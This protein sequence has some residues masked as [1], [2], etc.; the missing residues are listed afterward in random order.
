[1]NFLIIFLILILIG[2][3]IVQVG[4]VSDLASKLRG[5]EEVQLQNSNRSAISLVIFGVLFLVLCVWSA[6]YYKDQMLGYG[7]LKSASEHGSLVD[8]MFNV[9]LFFT[10]IVF[11]LTHIA[12][13]WYSY[14][15]RERKNGK[16]AFMAHDTKLEMVWT[17]VPAIVMAF[18]VVKGLV[19]WNDIMTDLGPEDEYLEIEATGYQFAWDIRYTGPDN[20]LGRK[21][22]RLI[23]PANN[24]LGLEWAD[25]ASLD[26]I[27]LGGSDVIKLPVDT[28][29]RVKITSKD[30]L[31]NFYLP[32]FRVKMDAVPGLPTYFIF[33]PTKTTEEFRLELSEYPEWNEPYDP[34]DPE[35]KTRWEEFNYELACAE[36][37]GKG[38]YSMRRIVEIVSKEEYNDWIAGQQSFYMKNIRGTE[39][40]PYSDKLFESEILSRKKELTA[41]FETKVAPDFE[42]KEGEDIILLKHVFYNTGSAAL[43]DLS[44]YELDNVSELMKKYPDVRLELRGHTDSVGDDEMNMELSNSRASNVKGYLLQKGIDDSRL[45]WKGYGE[46][47]PVD[48]NDTEEG[49]QNNRRTELRIISK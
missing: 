3:V 19:A 30:V 31:H 21:D 16:A 45:S 33:T 1:M 14:K 41:E 44:K 5:E 25:Y 22:F 12:L 35:S 26:D 8:S 37:C 9:T 24:S 42:L 43:K 40:D 48:S 23:D 27:V 47:L 13:F 4:K 28:T 32:H 17:L 36:L 11:V 34:E 46:T 20:Q 39:M 10:G 29:I 2:V 49:R 38:H 15:Y 7:P 6:I 18:L